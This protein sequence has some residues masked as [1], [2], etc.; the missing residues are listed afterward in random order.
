MPLGSHSCAHVRAYGLRQA[1]T[2]SSTHRP[3]TPSSDLVGSA[4][5]TIEGRSS[6]KGRRLRTLGFFL[7]ACLVVT[8]F[9]A[10]KVQSN[11]SGAR[12]HAR[13]LRLSAQLGERQ[14]QAR[15]LHHLRQHALPAGQPERPVRPRADA[16]PAQLHPRQRHAADERPHGPHLAHRERHPDLADGHVPGPPRTG[17]VRTRTATSRPTA[18]PRRRRRSSTGPISST[19]SASRR[20]TRC[21]TWST[22]T[23]ASPK[24]TPAPWVPYTRAGCDFGATATA[25][26]SCSRTRAPARTA[27]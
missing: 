27:T 1:V 24:N 7:I 5:S 20:P 14:H 2:A 8:G 16:A 25:P 9:A 6:M 11:G 12:A 17:R 23:A 4:G 15:H 22:G 21:R 19:T 18:R 26:T 10:A 13:C 3:L